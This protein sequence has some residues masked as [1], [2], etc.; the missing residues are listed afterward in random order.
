MISRRSTQP[1]ECEALH[2]RHVY[3]YIYGSVNK[4]THDASPTSTNGIDSIFVIDD[5][6][7]AYAIP[8][9]RLRSNLPNTLWNT[10]WLNSTRLD[11][12][13]SRSRPRH[14]R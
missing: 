9:R 14:E 2:A 5:L 4:L 11:S 8:I 12:I 7:A 10:A 13:P 3:T 6:L 1:V